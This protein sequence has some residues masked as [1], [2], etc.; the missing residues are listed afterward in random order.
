MVSC[1]L[2]AVSLAHPRFLFFYHCHAIIVTTL[3]AYTLVISATFLIFAQIY[4]IVKVSLAVNRRP[5]SEKKLYFLV[6]LLILA[7]S[8][9]GSALYGVYKKRRR[10]LVP[11][12]V[13]T[14]FVLFFIVGVVTSHGVEAWLLT[15]DT[16][17]DRFFYLF[18]ASIAFLTFFLAY[19]YLF[20]AVFRSYE[21]LGK[22]RRGTIDLPSIGTT[23]RA[24]TLE[25]FAAC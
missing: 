14:T 3:L 8:V 7:W 4:E 23:W 5:L 2:P 1:I 24:E 19:M 9:C 11:L 13:A 10:H 12:M 6:V 15:D 20:A 18:L 16:D 25:V 17:S 22:L 21:Y